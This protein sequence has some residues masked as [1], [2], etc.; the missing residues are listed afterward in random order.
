[1]TKCKE[2]RNKGILLFL[3]T[4]IILGFLNTKYFST[5]AAQTSRGYRVSF[6]NKE[7]SGLAN[8]KTFVGGKGTYK[9]SANYNYVITDGKVAPMA[10][11]ANIAV[12]LKSKRYGLTFI[13]GSKKTIANTSISMGST[14][15]S[16]QRGTVTW[17][18][19]PARDSMYL[20]TY[21]NAWGK[22][23]L[24]EGSGTLSYPS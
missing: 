6:S 2:N 8:D 24:I 10:R 12:E 17:N 7:V 23:Y 22:P 4:I 3:T 11:T 5:F 14:F 15:G 18:N 9:L 1:M 20:V 19:I 16:S 21:N 13:E